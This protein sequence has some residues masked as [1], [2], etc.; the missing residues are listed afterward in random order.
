MFHRF[1]R[2]SVKTNK[3]SFSSCQ[4]EPP[5]LFRFGYIGAFIIG[6]AFSES[7]RSDHILILRELREIKES[8]KKHK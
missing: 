8:L 4:Y 6:Y 7:L 3:R 2:L 1:S 5:F